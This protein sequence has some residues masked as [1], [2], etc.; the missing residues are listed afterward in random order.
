MIEI[1]TTTV[2]LRKL[3]RELGI[4]GMGSANKATLLPLVTAEVTR[5]NAEELAA[6]KLAA[7]K[8]ASEE[9]TRL[10]ALP[11]AE[12]AKPKTQKR[13]QQLSNHPD[14]CGPREA[15]PAK[16][17]KVSLTAEEWAMEENGHSDQGHDA[18]AQGEVEGIDAKYLAEIRECI[19][20]C[21]IC[22]PERFNKRPGYAAS[23]RYSV[24]RAGMQVNVTR[25]M[26][27]AE[28]AGKVAKE[29]VKSEITASE[30]FTRL[31]GTTKMGAAVELFWDL[32]GRFQHRSS[33][34][35]GRKVLNVAAALRRIEEAG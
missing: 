11:L 1:A 28:K 30:G 22:H 13:I 32:Q 7:E 12:Q 2:A 26:T 23:G 15:E 21:P 31:T 10:T 20:V 9:F 27:A 29:L 8:A 4:K 24:S 5:R 34:V 33:R 25:R 18:I 3:A 19:E 35:G 16:A 6:A 17:K 14:N